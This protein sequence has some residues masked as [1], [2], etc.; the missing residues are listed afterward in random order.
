MIE[1]ALVAVSCRGE[2]GASSTFGE[3]FDHVKHQRWDGFPYGVWSKPPGGTA[4][5]SIEVEPADTSDHATVSEQDKL[6]RKSQI[7]P[8]SA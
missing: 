8:T 7:F 5:V 2:Y 6:N 1:I 4:S 3:W